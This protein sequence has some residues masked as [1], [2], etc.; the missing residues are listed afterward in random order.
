MGSVKAAYRIDP[1]WSVSVGTDYLSGQKEGKNKV[2][3]FN[4]LYG[5]HHK[6][7]GSM[8]YFYASSFLPG[9]NTGLWDLYGG[10]TCKASG[11]VNVLLNYHYFSMAADVTHKNN[12]I[13][14]GLGSEFDLQMDCNIMKDV[15]FTL[16]YSVM[17]GTESMDIV[18]GGNHK[19]WQDWG[20]MSLNINPRV[21]YSKWL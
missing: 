12:T 1:T 3:A 11:K 7:Y 13:S 8:D 9:F 20:W 17:F 5:T 2:T 18:K 10:I 14:K 15:R 19:S 4:P 16:G 21:F 6:F